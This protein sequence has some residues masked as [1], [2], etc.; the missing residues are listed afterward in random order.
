MIPASWLV[1]IIPLAAALPAYIL[2]RWHALET[3]LA[4]V[5]CGL[6]VGLLSRPAQNPLSIAGFSVDTG[7]PVNL[8]GRVLVVREADRLPLLLLFAVAAVLF[9]LS[10]RISQGW[11]FIPLGLCMLSLISIGLLI[12]PFVFS[13][14]AFVAASALAAMM[15]QAENSGGGST[16]GA[17][18]YLILS[19]L[20]LPAFLGAGYAITQASGVSDPT[21]QAVAYS[22]AELLLIVGFGLLFGALPLY[23]WTHTVAKDAPPLATAFIAT[24]GIG[25]VTFLF[26]S[27]CQEF[28]WF[29]ESMQVYAAMNLLGIVTLVFGA[30]LGWAQRSLGRVLAC[31][32]SVEIGSTLLLLSH[33]T[34]VA[35]ETLAFAVASRALSL[36]LL[37]LGMAIL[38]QQAGSD[39]FNDLCGLGRQQLWAALAIGL[40]GMSLA[41]L[42]GTVGFVSR[43]TSAR[44][45]GQTD[46]E[47]M[48]LTFV[49]SASVGV[50]I[51]RSL[52]SLFAPG[53]PIHALDRE[54][55]SAASAT[56]GSIS[57]GLALTIAL[58]ALLVIVI[59]IAPVA[60]APVTKAIAGSYTF[61]K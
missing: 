47:A 37:G 43:W 6:T 22:P 56:R 25:A 50:G 3:L 46:L 18:R 9:A 35:V 31:G 26:L 23:T 20:A 45:L 27:F 42:P 59:G 30:G 13:A 4:V 14:L 17:L 57:R 51:W 33:S 15:I 32:L 55:V 49:A 11:T 2:R 61:Y 44:V 7:A 1:I 39:D 34:P 24:V 41:A 36:G 58:A 5:A 10:W 60:I 48:V 28:A 54:P 52:A 19:T 29:H 53:P 8:L 21:L 40:G 12:R 16:R 38:R